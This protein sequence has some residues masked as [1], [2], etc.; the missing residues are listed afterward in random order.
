MIEQ[1]D[2]TDSS[3]QLVDYYNPGV[4]YQI[5]RQL[6]LLTDQPL[7]PLDRQLLKGIYTNNCMEL[8]NPPLIK[9]PVLESEKKVEKKVAD[10]I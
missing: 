4:K 5:E 1:T 7:E 2:V 9:L 6:N 8:D 10:E 3:E